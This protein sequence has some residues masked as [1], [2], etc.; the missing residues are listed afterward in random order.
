MDSC[1]AEC[2]RLPVQEMYI[3]PCTCSTSISESTHS[4]SAVEEVV[5][6]LSW[7]HKV[8]GP[9]PP[10]SSPLVQSTIKGL[11]RKL[12]KP[13]TRTEPITTVDMLRAMVEA[14]GPYPSLTESGY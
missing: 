8:A 1:E 9:Q 2:S 12:A 3:W 7:L 6:T 10:S 14:A 11:R 13:S 5:H 4:K